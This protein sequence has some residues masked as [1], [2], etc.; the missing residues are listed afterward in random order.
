MDYGITVNLSGQSISVSQD[1]IAASTV[2]YITAK[3][4]FSSAW[5]GLDSWL[6]L[7]KD[8]E[9]YAISIGPDGVIDAN[10]HLNLGEGAWRLWAHG[11][12]VEDGVTTRRITTTVATL[13]V[14]SSGVT[15]GEPLPLVPAS[16]GEQILAVARSVR[17]DA[18]AGVFRGDP[19]KSAYETALEGGYVG[20]Q[21]TF[22]ADLAA[23]QGLAEEV[24]ALL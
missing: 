11:D 1:V 9:S 15:N 19:G 23:L 13:F 8:A 10:E 5:K 2:D 24:E 18:D 21:Q 14:R 12:S 6:H 22:Y 7:E 3:I 16:I 4:N 17:D 20:D